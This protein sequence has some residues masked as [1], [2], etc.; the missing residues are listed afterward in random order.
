MVQTIPAKYVGGDHRAFVGDQ[1]FIDVS[2]AFPTP[3]FNGKQ[4][5]VYNLLH[6]LLGSGAD[7]SSGGPGKGIHT[8]LSREIAFANYSLMNVGAYICPYSDS[9]LFYV[10][11][12]VCAD[13]K[14]ITQQL[15]AQLQKLDKVAQKDF[16][17]DEEIIRAKNRLKS[18]YLQ[19]AEE[20]TIN[21]SDL[22][23]QVLLQGGRP[24]AAELFKAL[25]DITPADV[26]KA[27]AEML[28]NKPTFVA[29][30]DIAGIPAYHEI[31]KAFSQFTR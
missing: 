27:V 25:D 22:G 2:I 20:E 21:A 15:V 31:E 5:L 16:K 7:F 4:F 28:S 18:H 1:Q 11:G 19:T 23:Y 13:G 8:R 24:S 6:F 17:T 9:G 14:T 10:T 12:R 29:T 26:S 30:G 3:G